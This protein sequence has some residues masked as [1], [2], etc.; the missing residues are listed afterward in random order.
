VYE[1]K[2]RYDNA[3]ALKRNLGIDKK[4]L[5]KMFSDFFIPALMNDLFKQIRKGAAD[6]LGS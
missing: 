3:K 4:K 6:D 2:V 1:V 5:A